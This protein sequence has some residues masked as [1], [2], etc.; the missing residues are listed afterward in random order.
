MEEIIYQLQCIQEKLKFIKREYPCVDFDI[1]VLDTCIT[2]L[3]NMNE[4][5]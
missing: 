5:N 4:D 3:K 1:D 2:Q